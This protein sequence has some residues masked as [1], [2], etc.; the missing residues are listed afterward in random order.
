LISFAASALRCA[1]LRTSLATTAKPR[2]CSPA[3]RRFHSRVQR[4]DVGLERD[5][6]DHADDVD[7]LLR[8]VVD[9]LHRVDDLAHDLA[10]L[11]RHGR[12]AERELGSPAA[13]L[14][15]FLLHGG[16]E[17]L[18]RRCCLLQRRSLL[19]GARRQ[20]GIALRDLRRS[21]GHRFGIAAHFA[22]DRREACFSSRAA[23]SAAAP[24]S[25]VPSA[26]N[27]IARSP[28]ATARTTDTASLIG[29]V[30]VRMIHHARQHGSD[31]REPEQH[32]HG[33][34]DARNGGVHLDA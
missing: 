26:L 3:R 23:P 12:C 16:A 14:S 17:L 6:V 1:R 4:E 31:E 34:L 33:R 21:R 19:L 22:D 29:R 11:H 10:A 30:V 13:R 15:A 18:H 27:S 2:P 28:A 32:G 8:A 7:D 20:V 9:A 5:A 24:V 25:F